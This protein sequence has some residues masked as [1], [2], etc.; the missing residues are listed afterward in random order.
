MRQSRYDAQHLCG[1]PQNCSTTLLVRVGSAEAPRLLSG[2]VFIGGGDDGPDQLECAREF[3]FVVV[4]EDF[5]DRGLRDFGKLIV[6]RMK[7]RGLGNFSAKA[8]VDHGSGAAGKI[9]QT[10][11]KIA[12]VTS[13][14]SLATEAAIPT[15]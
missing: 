13:D 14:Q 1:H 12:V 2:E 9:A 6:L 7:L 10:V 11:G 5:A 8:A 4:F 3:E 15:T